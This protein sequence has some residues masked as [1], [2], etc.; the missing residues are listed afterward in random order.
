MLNLH[1]LLKTIQQILQHL[2]ETIAVV[3]LVCLRGQLQNFVRS[4]Y[5]SGKKYL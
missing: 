3:Y 1:N 4:D 2:N 5:S